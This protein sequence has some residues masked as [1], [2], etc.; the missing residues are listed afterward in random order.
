MIG[1]EGGCPA[2]TLMAG[3]HHQQGLL[4]AP[5]AIQVEHS[6]VLF[7][8]TQQ[9]GRLVEQVSLLLRQPVVAAALP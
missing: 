6:A 2:A 9:S 8:R 1:G 4:S 5:Q 7:S 3:T